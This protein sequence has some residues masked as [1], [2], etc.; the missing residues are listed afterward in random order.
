MTG[1]ATNRRVAPDPRLPDGSYGFADRSAVEAAPDA[2]VEQPP[3]AVKL[4]HTLLPRLLAVAGALALLGTLGV[5]TVD[6]LRA[7]D[8][9]QPRPLLQ[10]RI[11]LA[12]AVL[13]LGGMWWYV[14]AAVN[15]RRVTPRHTVSPA[16]AVAVLVP[17]GAWFAID[18]I[19]E[20]DTRRWAWAGWAALLVI[21]NF[22]LA[23]GLRSSSAAMGHTN[24]HFTA[25]A[26]LPLVVAG[27]AVASVFQ[28]VAVFAL[29]M[30]AVMGIWVVVELWQGMTEWDGLCRER[31]QL[32]RDLPAIGESVAVAPDPVRVVAAVRPNEPTEERSHHTTTPRAMVVASFLL[33]L[34]TPAWVFLLER[35]GHVELAGRDTVVDAEGRRLLAALAVGMLG[36]YAIG[37][38]W[39]SAAAAANAGHRVPHAVSPLL[40]P[41]G[42]V[43]V[44]GVV[45]VVPVIDERVERGVEAWVLAAGVVIA[46]IAHFGV[47]SAY[48]RT[49]EAIKAPLAP[50]TRV[51]A[52]PWIA[53]VFSVLLAFFGQVLSD[54]AFDWIL[55][56]AWV[57]FY[58]VYAISFYQAMAGF[59]RACTGRSLPRQQ[60]N[61]V[62]DFLKKAAHLSDNGV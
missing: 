43:V 12:A 19:V 61:A 37:W 48:R 5:A 23:Q 54:F 38:L 29:P 42:Y 45:A 15:A 50:W 8:W 59:D 17:V 26:A 27:C 7:S 60:L 11:G 33:G 30:A 32:R 4:V 55:G 9:E 1:V 10:P 56:S 40:A 57:I 34:T 52:L 39:W 31:S 62:P 25:V 22:L 16:A 35:K 53:A 49:A 14:A 36:A 24:S 6:A 28:R 51:I 20:G 44:V 58:L 2:W 41:F 3:T 46:A 47:L 18:R 13:L 21:T